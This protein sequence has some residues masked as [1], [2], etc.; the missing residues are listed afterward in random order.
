MEFANKEYLFLLLL[1]IPYLIWY[2]MYRK[3]TEPTIRMSDTFAFRFAPKSWKV[4][5]MPLSM[6]LRVLA[7][8]MIILVLARPQTHNSWAS[9]TVGTSSDP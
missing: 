6:L 2:V 7:F 1:I 8:V 3:K 5:L 9:K 4:R